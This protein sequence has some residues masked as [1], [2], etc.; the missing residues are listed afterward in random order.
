HWSEL[1][2][3]GLPAG[4]VRALLTIGIVGTAWGLIVLHPDTA[5]PGY[6][7]DLL[8]L[9]LGHYFALRRGQGEPMEA[10]PP[11]LFLPRG[12]VRL[13]VVATFVATLVLVIRN[14]GLR[15]VDD[16]PAAYSLLL[17]LGFLLGVLS[18]RFAHF[19]KRRGHRPHRVFADAR[20]G[21]ALLAAIILLVLAWNQIYAFLP[22][23]RDVPLGRARV[24]LSQYGLEYV[25]S[26]VVGFYFGARS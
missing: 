6:L 21:I 17:V 20:A 13:L 2:P 4:S 25:F 11:P 19:L 26:A 14:G 1:Y 5:L 7:R 23:P 16:T 10:G 24:P 15:R 8:F 3:F 22:M 9:V 12:S 18:S